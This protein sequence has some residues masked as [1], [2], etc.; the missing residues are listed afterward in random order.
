MAMLLPAGMRRFRSCKHG[1]AVVLEI[2]PAKFDLAQYCA[3]A[4]ARVVLNGRFFLQNFIQSNQRRSAALKN[5][6]HPS[7]MQ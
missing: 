7:Q 6:D 5:I 4:G 2:Q 3:V 1:F